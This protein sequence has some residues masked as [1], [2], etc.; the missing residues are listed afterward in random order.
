[1]NNQSLTNATITFNKPKGWCHDFE[2][3]GISPKSRIFT[4]NFNDI[5]FCVADFHGQ[6]QRFLPK[7]VV[8]T[9]TALAMPL[10]QTFPPNPKLQ[11]CTPKTLLI[12]HISN[13]VVTST[14][15]TTQV[16]DN[17]RCY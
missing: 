13:I 12:E 14:G 17:F 9:P 2:R 8:H 15:S 3:G 16:I 4:V 5:F 10:K 1:M 6:F 11:T 7:G